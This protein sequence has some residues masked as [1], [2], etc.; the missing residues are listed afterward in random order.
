MIVGMLCG[1]FDNSICSIRRALQKHYRTPWFYR[2]AK[3]P[4]NR[5]AEENKPEWITHELQVQIRYEHA[6]GRIA[7]EFLPTRWRYM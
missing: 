6:S 3:F 7:L 4:K 5:D 2:G 1:H